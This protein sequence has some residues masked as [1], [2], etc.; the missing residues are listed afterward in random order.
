M[1]IQCD[2]RQQMHKKH[3]QI[4]E[5]WFI[6]HGHT[7]VHSKCLVADYI[8]PSNGSVAV[9]TKQSVSELYNDLIQ[10]H[11]RFH[12]ECVHAKEYGIKLY[13]LVENKYGYTKPE[14]IRTWKNPQYFQ[15][16]KARWNGVTR[17]P[18]ASNVTLIKIMHSMHRDYGVEFLFCD[19]NDAAKI[20]VKLLG[21]KHE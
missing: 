6:N 14:D 2:T 13:I 21:G 8:C 20:I 19:V 9:D 12:D 11:R 16:K 15:Y 3:H 7:V 18:P 5:K 4:K 1:V 17:K 10:D